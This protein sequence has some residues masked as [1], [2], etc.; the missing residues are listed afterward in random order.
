MAED[1]AH[2]SSSGTSSSGHSGLAQ[3][4]AQHWAKVE[5]E[6]G[7]FFEDPAGS[8]K[9]A[10]RELSS[11]AGDVG[12]ELRQKAE[13]AGTAGTA[14]DLAG[15]FARRWEEVDEEYGAPAKRGGPGASDL[16]QSA[17]EEHVEGAARLMEMEGVGDKGRG[18]VQKN[19]RDGHVFPDPG[20]RP[21]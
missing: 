13:Q 7:D 12:Q 8:A 19:E 21:V 5:D 10:A 6:Y 4:A 2:A 20:S 16:Q 1:E 17:D 9:A 11:K 18:K 15:S 3:E 14:A